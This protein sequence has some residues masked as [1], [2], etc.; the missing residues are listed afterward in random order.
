MLLDRVELELP[1]GAVPCGASRSDRADLCLRAAGS[2]LHVRVDEIRG[3]TPGPRCLRSE[4]STFDVGGERVP[5]FVLLESGAII[6]SRCVVHDDETATQVSFYVDQ[7]THSPRCD[8]LGTELARS[9]RS[10]GVA[11]AA[12][13]APIELDLDGG[14][15]TLDAPA[16]Y[17][18][19]TSD[20]RNAWCATGMQ[21][22]LSYELARANADGTEWA[23][24][25]VDV[26]RGFADGFGPELPP[27]YATSRSEP[28][29]GSTRTTWQW[30]DEGRHVWLARLSP[31]DASRR[32]PVVTLSIT[33][34]SAERLDE[35]RAMLA[36]ARLDSSTLR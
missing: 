18:L 21:Q 24:L 35:V 11:R 9:I 23:R 3:R 29:V 28:V 20:L 13:S 32:V 26:V 15:L 8:A 12:W 6:G 19:R 22:L 7:A 4:Q 5:M 25:A 30:A 16:E 14:T 31:S 2:E 36:A 10:T 27:P 17:V 33:A 34:S 1:I